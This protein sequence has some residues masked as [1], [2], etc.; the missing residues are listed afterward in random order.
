M[1]SSAPVRATSGQE[2]ISFS[3][4]EIAMPLYIIVVG[5][6]INGFAFIGPFPDHEGA[7]RYAEDMQTGADGWHITELVAAD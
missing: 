6:P 2:F 7:L 3:T 5:N 1:S 4:Q